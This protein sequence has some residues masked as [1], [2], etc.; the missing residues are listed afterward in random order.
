MSI[1]AEAIADLFGRIPALRALRGVERIEAEEAIRNAIADA[2]E[3]C[4]ENWMMAI[5]GSK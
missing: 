2:I 3:Q 1:E 5:G 4:R